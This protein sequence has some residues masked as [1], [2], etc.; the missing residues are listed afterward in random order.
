MKLVSGSSG[1]S[2]SE[3]MAACISSR[4]FRSFSM[5]LIQR[6][7]RLLGLAILQAA[8]RGPGDIQ[9]RRAVSTSPRSRA[10]WVSPGNHRA[11]P[12]W[13]AGTAGVER[14][15]VPGAAAALATSSA[16]FCTMST[17]MATTL[18]S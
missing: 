13:P 4:R 8:G 3:A 11:L 6:I 1:L 17:L 15:L 2:R 18:M 10:A 5:S 7:D 9:Q 12:G 16:R 14:P